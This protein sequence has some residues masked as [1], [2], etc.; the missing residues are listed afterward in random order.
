MS[1]EAVT[2]EQLA[3]QAISD[4]ATLSDQIPNFHVGD[5]LVTTNVNMRGTGSGGDRSFEQSVGMYIDGIYSGRGAL[6]AVPMTMDLERV[7]IPKL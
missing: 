1:V 7:E 3:N 5:G 6:A 2:G 4:F